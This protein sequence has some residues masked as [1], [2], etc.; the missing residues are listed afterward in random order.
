MY[1]VNESQ[2]LLGIIM[3]ILDAPNINFKDDFLIKNNNNKKL[4]SV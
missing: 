4:N 3:Y 1:K 2:E